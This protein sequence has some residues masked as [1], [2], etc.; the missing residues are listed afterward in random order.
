M[1]SIVFGLA[2]AIFFASS[3]LMSSRAVKVIGSWASV[4]W[5]MLVGL[6][7]VLPFVIAAG[8]PNA[9]T[10]NVGWL[11]VAGLG[12]VAGLVLVGYAFRVGKVGVV[13]PI[14]ATEGAI[15][16]VI[17]ALLG[18]SIAPIIAFLLA[19]IVMGIVIAAIAPDPAP[20]AH[21]RTVPA[22][23]LATGGAVAFGVSLYATGRLSGDLP[24]AW[25]LLPPRVVGV[26]AVTI[27]LA[28]MRRLRLTRSTVPLVIGM[29]IAEVAGFT[30]F[31]IGAQY[32]V[33]VTSVL[34]SQ[35]APIAAVMAYVL[36]RE[37]LGRLQITGVAIL[38]VAVSALALAS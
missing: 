34:A 2:T 32:Q 38:V 22:V 31:A 8:V 30:C 20:L 26:V 33:A 21:E 4:G 27:P 16:A 12:N 10:G 18:E 1:V 9:V 13:A 6:V 17:A 36:F 7:L 37:R 19:V 35:F 29:G 23:L 15:S 5:T 25:V 3:G 14:A 24:I 28:L 11:A